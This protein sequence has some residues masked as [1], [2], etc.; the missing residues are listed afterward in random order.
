[1]CQYRYQKHAFYRSA[2]NYICGCKKKQHLLNNSSLLFLHLSWFKTLSLRV[3]NEKTNNKVGHE[4]DLKWQKW[5]SMSQS[6]IPRFDFHYSEVGLYTKTTSL[7]T[8]IPFVLKNSYLLGYPT[9]KFIIWFR[10]RWRSKMQPL[11]VRKYGTTHALVVTYVYWSTDWCKF[12][13]A[14]KIGNL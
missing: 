11:P 14:L 5:V 2:N 7:R 3:G 10:V 8:V 1:M 6:F 13:C 12:W 9:T 4:H